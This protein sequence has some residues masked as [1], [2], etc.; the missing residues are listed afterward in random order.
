[1]NAQQFLDRMVAPGNYLVIA[2]RTTK[3]LHHQ[4]FPRNDTTEA[5]RL[6]TATA[7]RTDVWYLPR[8]TIARR[9][10]QQSRAAVYRGVLRKTFKPL[11][12]FWFDADIKRTGDGKKPGKVFADLNEVVHWVKDFSTATGIPLPNVWVNSGYGVHLY[13]TLTTALP[14]DQWKPHAEA[15]KAALIKHG[16][17]GDTSVVADS[18]RLLRPIGTFNYKGPSNPTPCDLRIGGPTRTTPMPTCWQRC[19]LPVVEV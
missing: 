11:N 19:P 1:M 3:G 12:A 15:L 14:R 2:Y 10:R 16:A 17:K 13:W 4:F 18:A 9:L 6:I 8:V 7:S 5:A